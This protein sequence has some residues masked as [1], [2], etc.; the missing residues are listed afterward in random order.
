[1]KAPEIDYEKQEVFHKG[2]Y[3]QLK[4]LKELSKELWPEL[5]KEY[6]FAKR[7]N[8]KTGEIDAIISWG[9]I[10][11]IIDKKIGGGSG[12]RTMLDLILVKED[13]I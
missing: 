7:F 2:Y 9:S 11:H 12:L 10:F 5:I 6:S 3:V 13:L 8:S 4:K 1:M